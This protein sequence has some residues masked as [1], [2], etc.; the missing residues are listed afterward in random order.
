[1]L[2]PSG[3]EEESK[4]RYILTWMVDT[5]VYYDMFYKVYNYI[6]VY[7]QNEVKVIGHKLDFKIIT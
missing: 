5:V 2:V 7:A 6:Y 4:K 1:M 3:Q